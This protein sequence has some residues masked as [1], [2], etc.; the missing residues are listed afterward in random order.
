RV[1]FILRARVLE[2]LIADGVRKYD[3]LGGEPGYKARW[4]AQLGY[5]ECV[6]FAR[7]FSLGSAYLYGTDTA[8]TG[9]AWL[10]E[11]LP[12]SAWDVLHYLNCKLRGTPI[13]KLQ[14][15]Q[16]KDG[17]REE[18]PKQIKTGLQSSRAEKN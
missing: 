3:F 1:G 9:K 16:S 12:K 14:T 18:D 5:Y 13:R 8:K 4:L 11:H 2:Q 6:H 17:R 15:Q 7:P 10:R